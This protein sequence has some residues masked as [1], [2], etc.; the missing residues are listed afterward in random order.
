MGEVVEVAPQGA[1]FA[2]A[3]VDRR[4]YLQQGVK[5]PGVRCLY[6]EATHRSVG[7]TAWGGAWGRPSE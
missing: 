6:A 4:D 7:D 5:M 1:N 3:E 2:G